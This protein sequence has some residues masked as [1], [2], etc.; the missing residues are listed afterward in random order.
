[1]QLTAVVLA[2]YTSGAAGSIDIEVLAR[3][4][5]HSPHQAEE[6]LDR[7][8]APRSLAAWRYCRDTGEV[9]W[10]LSFQVRVG[11]TAVQQ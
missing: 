9:A 3:L 5:G 4:C 7:M 8:V 10:R 2:T 11:R 6:L 1:M